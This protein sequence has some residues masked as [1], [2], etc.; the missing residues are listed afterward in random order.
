MSAQARDLDLLVW[1]VVIYSGRVK[2][3]KRTE[4]RREERTIGHFV[5]R[6]NVR[7]CVD[8]NLLLPVDRDD[9]SG[10]VGST[11]VVDET[12]EKGGERNCQ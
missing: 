1:E 9:A 11:A 6:P 5:A 10:T 3:A 8:D 12:S 7:L 4:A 2:S